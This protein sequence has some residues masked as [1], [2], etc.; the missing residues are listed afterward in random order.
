MHVK[1]VPNPAAPYRATDYPMFA[2]SQDVNDVHANASS[3]KM[4]TGTI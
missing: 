2:T 4:Q 1:M 3:L